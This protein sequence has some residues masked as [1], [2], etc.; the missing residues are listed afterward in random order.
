MQQQDKELFRDYEIRNWNYSPRL[1]KILAGAAVFNLLAIFVMGQTDILTTRGCDSPMVSRVCQVIDTIYVG[2]VLLG[3]DREDV[4]KDYEKTELADADITYID[5]SGVTPPLTYPEG[6]FALAN[7]E[8]QFTAM[9]NPADFSMTNPIPGIPGFPTTPAITGGTDLM[10]TPQVTPTPNNNAITGIVPDKPFSMSDNPIATT[11]PIRNRKFPRS[12]NRKPL[13]YNSP[14]KLPKFEDGT[15]AENKIEDKQ[16]GKQEDKQIDKTQKELKSDP[17]AEIEINKKPIKDLGAFVNTLLKDE[18]NKLNLQAHFTA[19]ATGKLT[20]EG[21]LDPKTYKIEAKSADEKMVE[22]VQESIEA[23]NDAGYLQYLKKLS[24]KDL[25]LMLQQDETGITAVVQSELKDADEAR[26]LKN[27]LNLSI[28][29][30][31]LTKTGAD[32]KDD[33]ELLNGATVENDG[34]KI[35]IKFAIKNPLAQEMIKRKLLEQETKPQTNNTAKSVSTS[36]TN[37]K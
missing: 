30:A 34:K 33:L 8:D 29:I 28:S 2:S 7:P 31:K 23:L 16:E 22:V 3:T 27:A 1:Y 17:V 15:T 35:V 14:P 32:D 13:K 20:K 36:Q 37:T 26:S 19:T 4:D 25:S 12:V 24:G 11:P 21:K 5:V 18:K 6:Y 9:Q 10:N